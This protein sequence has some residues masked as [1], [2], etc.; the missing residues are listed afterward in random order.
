MINEHGQKFS[1]SSGYRKN[2]TTESESEDSDSENFTAYENSSSILTPWNK[3]NKC[4]FE[5]KNH[6]GFKVHMSAEHK[7]KCDKCSFRTTTKS[8][9]NKHMKEFHIFST[10]LPNSLGPASYLL[11]GFV[12]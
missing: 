6:S 2:S 8:L 3:C 11:F 9:V 1:F 4:N 7:L 10:W 12:Q 5:G